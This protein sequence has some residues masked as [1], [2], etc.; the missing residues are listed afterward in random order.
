M[1]KFLILVLFTAVGCSHLVHSPKPTPDDR[2]PASDSSPLKKLE[3]VYSNIVTCESG[4]KPEDT[5]TS[6]EKIY[7]KVLESGQ[8]TFWNLRTEGAPYCEFLGT[9]GFSQIDGNRIRV[10]VQNI[11]SP[12]CENQI[13]EDYAPIDQSF[14]E[15]TTG[16]KFKYP[17]R[18]MDICKPG[19]FIVLNYTRLNEP[20][21]DAPVQMC[22]PRYINRPK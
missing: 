15:T 5:S 16:F 4:D 10:K 8:G 1:R 12:I 11:C 17:A 20:Y 18:E 22:T 14:E 19:D 2:Q 21:K 9:G 3:G 7:I 6:N 13:I